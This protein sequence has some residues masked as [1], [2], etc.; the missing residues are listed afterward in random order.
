MES[1]PP[2]HYIK[3]GVI[4]FGARLSIFEVCS[5]TNT[6]FPSVRIQKLRPPN[7]CMHIA[8][9]VTL[10]MTPSSPSCPSSL[11]CDLQNQGFVQNGQYADH[12]ETFTEF[13]KKYIGLEPCA[14]LTPFTIRLTA[15]IFSYIIHQTIRS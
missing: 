4:N 8:K 13:D 6:Q 15:E 1:F 9:A 2:L 3:A 11:S 5:Q 14:P 7:S 10:T 12:V